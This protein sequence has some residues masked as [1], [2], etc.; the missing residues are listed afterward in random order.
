MKKSS[1]SIL[2]AG[3][4]LAFCATAQTTSPVGL[5]KN[6]DDSTGKPKALIR[7]TES[8]G[9]LSGKIEKLFREPNEEANPKCVKCEGD[10]KDKPIVGLTM[11]QGMKADGAEYSGGTILDPANGK[12]YKSKMSLLDDGKKLS[13]RGYIGVP[14]LGRS[15]TWVREE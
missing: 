3:L 1:M 14:L 11:L 6:I 12:V 5:W 4:L 2:A 10:N 9:E 7:I 13:V 8:G 15:Q